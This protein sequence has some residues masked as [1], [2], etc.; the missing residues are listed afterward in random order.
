MGPYTRIRLGYDS[1][2]RPIDTD[3]RQKQAFDQACKKS[4]VTPTI[5]QGAYR[6]GNGAVASAGTHDG[7]G[8]FD[9]RTWNLT[10]TQ[11]Q[12]FQRASRSI[13]GTCWYRTPSQGFDYH[14]HDG[15]LGHKTA[16]SGLKQQ[17]SMYKAGYNG[18]A[19]WGRDDFWRPNPIPRFRYK[20]KR[21]KPRINLTVLQKAWG[22]KRGKTYGLGKSIHRKFAKQLHKKGFLPRY[23]WKEAIFG[24]NLRTAVRKANRT[25]GITKYTGPLNARPTWALC[26]K[27]GFQPYRVKVEKRP[28]RKKIRPFKKSTS[29]TVK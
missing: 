5:V 3:K 25:Y 11:R 16:S 18:L 20:K 15:L 27:L 7:G 4:G 13:G 2:G 23:T 6:A 9:L 8:V 24:R 12:A 29:K 19:S 10:T 22:R 28:N 1:S 26:K 17:F 14:M 21:S